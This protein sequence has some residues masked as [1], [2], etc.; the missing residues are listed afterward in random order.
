MTTQHPIT[1][2]GPNAYRHTDWQASQHASDAEQAQAIQERDGVPRK[3]RELPKS[4]QLPRGIILDDTD[5]AAN[6]FI[7]QWEE[8]QKDDPETWPGPRIRHRHWQY[9]SWRNPQ[10]WFQVVQSM[11]GFWAF[12]SGITYVLLMFIKWEWSHPF[13]LVALVFLYA[14]IAFYFLT[15]GINWFLNHHYT[16]FWGRYDTRYSRERGTVRIHSIR[17]NVPVELP[18]AEYDAYVYELVQ[19]S[20]TAHLG[21]Y[22]AHRYHPVG[23]TY[24]D[25]SSL[26]QL[27]FDWQALQQFMDVDKPLADTPLNDWHRHLDPTS[28]AYDQQ[29]NRPPF[30]WRDMTEA[31]AKAA[32][33]AADKDVWGK[34]GNPLF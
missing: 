33:K 20:G 12:F 25:Y 14:P 30:K 11:A 22:L 10:A 9:P 4:R 29:S 24:G 23:V 21:L 16:E 15:R 32:I 5:F 7:E 8:M 13:T 26:Q 2:Y 34:L 18:F 27:L 31:E 28:I 6:A 19:R 1:T 17:R 3:L